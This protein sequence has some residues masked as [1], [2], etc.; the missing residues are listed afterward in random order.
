MVIMLRTMKLGLI[1]FRPT[2]GPKNKDP[3]SGIAIQRVESTS[4]GREEIPMEF[5]VTPGL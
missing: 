4:V 5:L 3:L 1:H 2:M